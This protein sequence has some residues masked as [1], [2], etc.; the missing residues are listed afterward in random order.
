MST[1]CHKSMPK[2]YSISL[3][4]CTMNRPDELDRCLESV[5]Q[6]VE[7]PDEVIVSDDSPNSEP[8]QAIVAKYPGAVYQHG[9]R[10]GLGPNRN[11]CIRR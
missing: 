11:A 3:C 5:F 2:S 7:Q 9:P 8:I 4:I 10:R 6:S 1:E